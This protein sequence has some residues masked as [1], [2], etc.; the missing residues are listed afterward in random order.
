MRTTIIELS[1]VK[2][3]LCFSVR[4]MAAM[5]A[6]GGTYAEFVQG[7][8]R[9]DNRMFMLSELLQAGYIYDKRQELDPPKPPSL[10]ELLDI[11][12][13][14]DVETINAAIVEALAAGNQRTVEAKPTK[15]AH[16]ATQAE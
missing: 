3:T 2:Y 9:V 6:K 15:K 12:G 1:G 4:C 14:D 10:E 11:L 13:P 8:D 7:L 5:E 16:G